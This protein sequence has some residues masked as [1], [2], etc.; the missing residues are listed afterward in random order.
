MDPYNIVPSAQYDPSPTRTIQD[1]S[2]FH[3]YYYYYYYHYYYYY[4]KV[5]LLCACPYINMFALG[6]LQ[7]EL[8]QKR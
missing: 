3:D 7:N 5:Y 1:I 2:D 8:R 6:T 4:Y